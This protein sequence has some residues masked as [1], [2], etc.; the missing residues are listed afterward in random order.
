MASYGST[1]AHLDC[2]S[3]A[4]ED[5]LDP[6]ATAIEYAAPYIAEF[7]GC[8]FIVFTWGTTHI[9]SEH[10]WNPTGCAFAVVVA[11]YSFFSIS[12]AHLNPAVTLTLAFVLKFPWTRTTGYIITQVLGSIAGS[13]TYWA[14][15]GEAVPL[16]P[17]TEMHTFQWYDVSLIEALYTFMLSF[18]YVNCVASAR[19]NK[20]NDQNH[21]FA[22]A[23]GFVYIAGGYSAL[24]ISGG[25]FNPAASIAYAVTGR[26]YEWALIYTLAQIA[27]A[28]VASVAFAIVRPEDFKLQYDGSIADYEVP[29]RAKWSSELIGTFLIVVTVG[30]NLVM[31]GPAGPWSTGACYI[32]LIY[33]LGDVSGGHFNPAVTLAVMLSRRPV[34]GANFD[35]GTTYI[36]QQCLGGLGAA[37]LYSHFDIVGNQGAIPLQPKEGYGWKEAGMAEVLFTALLAFVFLAVATT[38]MAP[39]TTKT[40]FYFGLAAGSCVTIG[41]FAIGT[42]SGG[43]LNP[44]VALGRA[45]A[46]VI[47][48]ASINSV[49]KDWR[50]LMNFAWYSLFELAGGALG[51]SMFF[52]THQ[53]EYLKDGSGFPHLP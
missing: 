25:M 50:Q 18:V 36:I 44:A 43:I 27:G 32:S 40:N 15:F 24:D 35:M 33:A 38:T 8:F 12:G 16:R 9:C 17:P 23:I 45:F 14:L 31:K 48:Y 4:K 51:A 47:T 5:K 29:I 34:H 19:N 11:V 6:E 3:D 7:I 13:M 46:Q 42:L 28:W 20:A 26:D 30:F 2:R 1:Q 22:L 41:G 21:F 49:A 37:V 52:L 39:S 53:R 10:M